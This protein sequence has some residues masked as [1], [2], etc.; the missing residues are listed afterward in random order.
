MSTED[1]ERVE[2]LARAERVDGIIAPGIDWPVAIAARV[3][4]HLGLTHP[5][6]PDTASD[7]VSKVRQRRRFEEGVPQPRW[8]LVGATGDG[9]EIR[10]PCVVK[11]P[12][13][14]GQRGL[15]LVQSEDELA[16]ALA[17]AAE[18]SRTDA[19]L[20]EELAEGPEVTVNAFSVD[21]V[22]QPLTV[23]DRL[24]AEPPAFGVALA[25]AWPSPADPE[26]RPRP[27]GGRSRS[28]DPERADL[29]ADPD[30]AGGA[31]GHGGR[32]PARRRTR[33]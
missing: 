14:Q 20:V 17:H 24:T 21:G 7:A 19:V 5:L 33:R 29:H 16:P 2:Q 23:T 31:E 3:A 11:P 26:P 13:R 9:L 1:E 27:P 32:R 6:D 8:Q 12:D 30:R 15:S 10:P 18:A 28:R 22:F 25:H 4:H